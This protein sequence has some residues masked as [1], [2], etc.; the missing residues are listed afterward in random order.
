VD[1]LPQRSKLQPEDA[2]DTGAGADRQCRGERGESRETRLQSII[3]RRKPDELE[4]ARVVGANLVSR[5]VSDVDEEHG[6]TRYA[7]VDRVDDRA[8]ERG[9]GLR[10]GTEPSDQ[11]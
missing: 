3:A 1:R 4:P 8:A 10:R 6:R 11:D 5:I 2:F 9:Q 7:P